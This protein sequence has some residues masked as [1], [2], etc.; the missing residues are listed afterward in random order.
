MTLSAVLIIVESDG[1]LNRDPT[2]PEL[3]AAES[4][5]VLA[6]S[7]RGGLLIAESEGEFGMKVWENVYCEGLRVCRGSNNSDVDMGDSGDHVES[8]GT[9]EAFIHTTVEKQ[10]LQNQEWKDSLK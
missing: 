3:R 6:F 8:K 4:T 7:S 10:A 9:I 5:H 1:N 2:L